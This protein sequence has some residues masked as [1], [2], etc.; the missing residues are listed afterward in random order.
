[1][2]FWLKNTN[3][4]NQQHVYRLPIVFKRILTGVGALILLLAIGRHGFVKLTRLK[5]IFRGW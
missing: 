4:R 3:K 2:I 1:M 5:R